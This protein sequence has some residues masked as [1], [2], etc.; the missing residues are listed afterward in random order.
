MD[1][2]FPYQ[3][4]PTAPPPLECG[5]KGCLF[6]ELVARAPTDIHSMLSCLVDNPAWRLTWALASMRDASDRVAVEGFYDDVLPPTPE[7]RANLRN[8]RSYL[9]WPREQAGVERLRLAGRRGEE[10]MLEELFFQPSPLNVQGITSGWQGDG[11]KTITPGEAVAKI[12]IRLVARQDGKKV[13]NAIRRHLDRNG[14][15]DLEIRGVDITPWSRSPTDSFPVRAAAQACRDLGWEPMVVPTD[16]GTGPSYLFTNNPPL[17]LQEFFGGLG[18][19]G[20]IHAPNEYFLVEGFRL[21]EKSAVNYLMHLPE[22]FEASRAG[23]TPS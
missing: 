6:F 20:N 5:F 16:P 19:G 15:A 8:L 12:D 18:H 22:A 2:Y 9:D 17:Q 21:F 13:L 10:E 7:E 14:F 11:C 3:P 4:T 23:G 1:G